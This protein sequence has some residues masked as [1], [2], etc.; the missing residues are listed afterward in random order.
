MADHLGSVRGVYEAFARGDVAGALAVLAPDV[1]W[2][3]AEGFPYGGTY[4]GPSAVLEGVF[5]RLAT[6]WDGFSAV[7][8]E[9]VAQGD[10]VVALGE[11]GGT[12]KKTGKRFSAPFAHVWSFRNG[13]V[14][15]FRQYTDTVVVRS[16]MK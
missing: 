3:E 2:V 9:F 8:H 7:P 6:E 5:K 14:A 1:S 15:K 16:A 10:T 11:Y 13:K 4:V 12:Y